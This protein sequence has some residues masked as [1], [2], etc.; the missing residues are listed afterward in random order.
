MHDPRPEKDRR[1]EGGLRV[2][3]AAH[4][5]D[6]NEHGE[7]REVLEHILMRAPRPLGPRRQGRHVLPVPEDVDDSPLRPHGEAV[8]QDETPREHGARQ[9]HRKVAR[10]PPPRTIPPPSPQTPTSAAPAPPR[11]T[12]PP[13]WNTPWS[14]KSAMALTSMTG[15]DA[16]PSCTSQRGSPPRS[17]PE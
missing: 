16:M 17:R 2:R 6:E 4:V 1:A 15:T 9:E 13:N 5:R 8:R 10:H 3:D 11:S 14:T 7:V 12:S